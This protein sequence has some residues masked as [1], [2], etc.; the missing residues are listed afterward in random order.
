MLLV[1]LKLLLP[2]MLLMLPVT[3]LQM[4]Q[5]QGP[6]YAFGLD[7]LASWLFHRHMI[8]SKQKAQESCYIW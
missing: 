7:N 8:V 2:S 3:S 1:R 6:V 5:W 4:Y